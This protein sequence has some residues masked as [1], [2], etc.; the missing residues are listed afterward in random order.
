MQDSEDTG[1]IEIRI[2][3]GSDPALVWKV[4]GHRSLEVVREARNALFTLVGPYAYM[5]PPSIDPQ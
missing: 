2:K 5:D 3:F 1:E 4:P